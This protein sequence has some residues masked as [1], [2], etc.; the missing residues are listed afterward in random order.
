MTGKSSGKFDC[1]HFVR[2]VQAEIAKETAGMT[3][4]KRIE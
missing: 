2:K 4:S 1:I 3:S